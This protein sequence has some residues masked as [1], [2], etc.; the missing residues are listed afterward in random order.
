MADF[1]T[2]PSPVGA[3]LPAIKGEALARHR[4]AFIAGKPAATGKA[5]CS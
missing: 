4:G 5:L 3:G 2:P 1:A